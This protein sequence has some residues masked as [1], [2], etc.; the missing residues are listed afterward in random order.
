MNNDLEKA[1][2]L[3]NK[4]KKI[5]I[6]TGAGISAASGISCRVLDDEIFEPEPVKY[7]D[8]IAS[9]KSK[10][11]HWKYKYSQ[12]TR[13]KDAC[14]N[15]AHKALTALEKSGKMLAL[16][17]QNEDSL[18]RNAGT[19][20]DKLI[21]LHGSNLY[22]ECLDCFDWTSME[23][24]YENFAKYG[25]PPQCACGGWLKPSQIMRGQ[26][27]ER[28]ELIKA[29]KAAEQCDLVISIG[30]SLNGKTSSSVPLSAKVSGK[31]YIIIN[32]GKTAQDKAADI[33]I[34]GKAE[35]ILPEIIDYCKI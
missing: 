32:L 26:E 9:T 4:S 10:L 23:E 14:P 15:N 18:H 24:A 3:I 17:T 13:F 5:L 25:T 6:F 19:N 34:L 31:P 7:D 11:E 8:F 21:E 28:E 29:F 30:S 22:A 33:K 1:A 12:F 2:E 20:T 35:N 27:I 16:A